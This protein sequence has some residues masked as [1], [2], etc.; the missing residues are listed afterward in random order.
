MK[1]NV[2]DEFNDNSEVEM[3]DP[4]YSLVSLS[5]STTH[6]LDSTLSDREREVVFISRREIDLIDCA[7]LGVM[8]GSGS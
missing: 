5:A 1:N 6:H 4:S 2:H 8:Y 7:S 3:S